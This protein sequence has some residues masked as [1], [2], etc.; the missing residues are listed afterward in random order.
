M[1]DDT[2]TINPWAI[3][4]DKGEHGES[5]RRFTYWITYFGVTHGKAMKGIDDQWIALNISG[6]QAMHKPPVSAP[7]L[8]E[9]V[10]ALRERE[11]QS[12]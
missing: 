12:A 2:T 5:A 8:P 7:T 11:A 4:K 1:S 9:L 10:E 6:Y 3:R